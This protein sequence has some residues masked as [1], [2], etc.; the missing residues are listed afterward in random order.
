MGSLFL[1]IEGKFDVKYFIKYFCVADSMS[2]TWEWRSEPL[3]RDHH[4]QRWLIHTR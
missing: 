1:S 2:S 4:L 3:R